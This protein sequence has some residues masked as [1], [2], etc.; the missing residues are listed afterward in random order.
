MRVL[1][2]GGCGYIGSHQVLALLEAG[3][4]VCVVDD[5]ST[6]AP[7]S[8]DRVAEITRQR[9]EFHCFDVAETARLVAVLRQFEADAIIHFASFKHVSESTQRGFDY[10]LNN[11]G[12]LLSVVRAASE[13]QVHR[14]IFSS[15]ASVYGETDELPITEDHPHNPTN[16]YSAT[17]SIGERILSDLCASDDA[18]SISALRYFNPAGAHPS[19]LIGENP[20]GPA[21]NLLP[22]LMRAAL[23]DEPEIEIFGTDF[24]TPDGSGIRD[25]VHVMDVADCH[26]R[27]LERME[28]GQGFTALNIGRGFGISVYEMIDAVERASHRKFTIHRRPRR[29]GD[30]S[31]LY[32]DTTAAQAIFGPLEYRS[33]TEIC[34]DA[35]RWQSKCCETS[36]RQG[37]ER[38]GE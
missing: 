37:G 13:A 14:I 15:S 20:V 29:P 24:D 33:L 5:L 9:A 10:H 12:G 8:L 19:G 2:T 18:W 35:W 1:V 26:L 6:S 4:D 27:A 38:Q 34:E 22:A 7:G 28:G 21:T 31:A 3:H 30:V 23:N 16:P 36:S 25:Y 32:G 11:V 17:K